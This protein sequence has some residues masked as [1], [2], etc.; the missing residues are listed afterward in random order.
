[1]KIFGLYLAKQNIIG[2]HFVFFAYFNMAFNFCCCY[3]GGL[4]SLRITLQHISTKAALQIQ[5]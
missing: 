4:I 2:T 5:A 1:M 3:T